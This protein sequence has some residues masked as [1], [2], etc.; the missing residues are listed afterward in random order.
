M[1]R[2]QNKFKIGQW[3]LLTKLLLLLLS[4]TC[5]VT[6]YKLFPKHF[7]FLFFCSDFFFASILLH[8]LCCKLTFSCG[9]FSVQTKLRLT[10]VLVSCYM[11]KAFKAPFLKSED[12]FN[13][14][15]IPRM[16]HTYLGQSNFCLCARV[17]N[18]NTGQI[19]KCYF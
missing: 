10:T 4:N 13:S 12:N 9:G 7:V 5:G 2:T 11:K 19:M 8:L 1:K 14:F 15:N 16:Y 6:W 18:D 3:R 17:T